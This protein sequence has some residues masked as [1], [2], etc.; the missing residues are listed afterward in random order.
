MHKT[1]RTPFSTHFQQ[2]Q[3]KQMIKWMFCIKHYSLPPS[4]NIVHSYEGLRLSNFFAGVLETNQDKIFLRTEKW[5]KR[6]TMSAC[7]PIY[8]LVGRN[9]ATYSCS[10]NYPV[11]QAK[12]MICYRHVNLLPFFEMNTIGI[13]T[14]LKYCFFWNLYLSYNFNLNSLC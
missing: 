1:G 12:F 2:N 10:T 8:P 7:K 4:E 14:Q 11:L 3:K 5:A 6:F 9:G 13:R